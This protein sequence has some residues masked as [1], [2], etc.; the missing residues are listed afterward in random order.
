MAPSTILPQQQGP[1]V[2]KKAYTWIG[3]ITQHCMTLLLW[4]YNY[5]DVTYSVW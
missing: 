4:Q 2:P 1:E 3:K 5:V